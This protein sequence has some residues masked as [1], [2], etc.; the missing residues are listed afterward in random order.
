MV[1]NLE[2]LSWG[3]RYRAV[4]SVAGDSGCWGRAMAP[5]LKLASIV[6][7]KDDHS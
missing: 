2:V 3:I 1:P 5:E 6:A 4:V 7:D